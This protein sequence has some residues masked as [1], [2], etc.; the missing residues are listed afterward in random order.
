MCLHNSGWIVETKSEEVICTAEVLIADILSVNPERILSM[1]LPLTYLEPP[2]KQDAQNADAKEVAA[3]ELK[4]IIKNLSSIASFIHPPN[5]DYIEGVK[6]DSEKFSKQ[7]LK[8]GISRLKR[9][10]TACGLFI[11]QIENIFRS[12][13]QLFSYLCLLVKFDFE[14][15][16]IIKDCDSF[17][18]AL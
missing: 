3:P 17:D 2:K 16:L 6:F 13:Y 4:V 1:N 12:K 10:F 11:N 15:S 14:F 7:S 8:L 18:F 9:I 5:T